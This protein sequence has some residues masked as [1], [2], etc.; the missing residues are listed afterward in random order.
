MESSIKNRIIYSVFH[1]ELSQTPG[2]LTTIVAL[3]TEVSG[4][5]ESEGELV[6]DTV[7]NYYGHVLLDTL[8]SNFWG[9]MDRGERGF[10]CWEKVF[11]EDVFWN[12]LK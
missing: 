1:P 7:V 11:L 4:E 8:F 6:R 5:G 2:D 3:N 12:F 9:F 10:S